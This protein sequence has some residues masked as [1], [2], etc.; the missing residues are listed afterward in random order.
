MILSPK[1]KH[2]IQASGGEAFLSVFFSCFSESFHKQLKMIFHIGI[3]L[4]GNLY[5]GG[6]VL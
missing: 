6:I 2:K 5:T 4:K 3:M 1:Q